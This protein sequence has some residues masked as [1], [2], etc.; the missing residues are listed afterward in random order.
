QIGCRGQ[1]VRRAHAACE[2]IPGTSRPA[3]AELIARFESHR[4]SFIAAR[5]ERQRQSPNPRAF[6]MRRITPCGMPSGLRSAASA[7]SASSSSAIKHS[8]RSSSVG[9]ETFF[10]SCYGHQLISVIAIVPAVPPC[11]AAHF[12]PGV[13]VIYS[14]TL[15]PSTR[16]LVVQVGVPSAT[17]KYAGWVP[18]ATRHPAG[19]G[20][21]VWPC[22]WDRDALRLRNPMPV[23]L[24]N[25][26]AGFRQT[27]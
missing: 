6:I 5:Y 9:M 21:I 22:W 14:T 1:R 17:L 23:F 24:D 7:S 16:S 4:F 13:T 12:C 8:T 27:G 10:L 18:V 20:S 3:A 15:L 11:S 26:I 2:P 25:V 19:L